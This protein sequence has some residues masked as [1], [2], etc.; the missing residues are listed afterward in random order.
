MRLSSLN[1][2]SYLF[3]IACSSENKEPT[4]SGG[5]DAIL[6]D[7]EQ[8]G[9]IV[10][11]AESNPDFQD[12]DNIVV[13]DEQVDLGTNLVGSSTQ[14][15][16]LTANSA[17]EPVTKLYCRVLDENQ[18]P[19][20]L[21]GSGIDAAWSFIIAYDEA[22]SSIKPSDV[23]GWDIYFHAE[24]DRVVK[25][26]FAADVVTIAVELSYEDQIV[27]DLPMSERLLIGEDCDPDAAGIEF[28]VGGTREVNGNSSMSGGNDRRVWARDGAQLVISSTTAQFFVEAGATVDDSGPGSLVIATAGSQYEGNGS[29]GI[30]YFKGEAAITNPSNRNYE[31][32]S[33]FKF[34]QP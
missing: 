11:P 18:S 25:S 3:I 12:G 21:A 30:V 31:F 17:A 8:S 26:I 28:S 34:C 19:I 32:K 16:Q 14:C 23:E 1:L 4:F 15:Q 10:L 5:G 27:S 2:I 7:I 24:A 29:D 33:D 9:R 22:T 13:I 6:G 20:N